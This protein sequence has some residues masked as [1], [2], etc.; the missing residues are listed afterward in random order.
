MNKYTFTYEY[1]DADEKQKVASVYVVENVTQIEDILHSVQNFLSSAGYR[2][3]KNQ[4][5]DVISIEGD[6]NAR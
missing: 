5:I 1:I 3:E 6:K 2:F 4:V